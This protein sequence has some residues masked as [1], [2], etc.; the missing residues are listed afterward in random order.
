MNKHRILTST[1]LVLSAL[2]CPMEMF[3]Q[4]DA[5]LPSETD[6]L[7]VIATQKGHPVTDLR[8]EELQ[9]SVG[10]ITQSIS[11]LTYRSPLPMR[12]GVLIDASGSQKA[13]LDTVI[14]LARGFLRRAIRPGDQA[15]VIHFT[16]LAYIDARPTDNFSLLED[17][18][19]RLAAVVPHG[20]TAL[21]DAILT[22][23]FPREVTGPI[24]RVLVAVTDGRDNA[25]RYTLAEMKAIVENTHTQLFFVG[26]SPDR[27][28]GLDRLG[29]R[30][31]DSTANAT[32]GVFIPTS[33]VR[34][35]EPALTR[36][37]NFSG[38]STH[39]SLSRIASQLAKALI[40]SRSLAPGEA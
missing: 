37:R 5:S 25:S 14:S 29:F 12:L 11:G 3:G 33:N 15:F 9:L 7:W 23:C 34:Q 19:G 32:G 35:L 17:G 8:K 22:A 6:G 1:L 16:D 18:L 30:I 38:P 21:Y 20:G 13:A 39:W 2:T 27:H 24:H 31:L 36:L 10:E 40:V 28:S 4:A 26:T